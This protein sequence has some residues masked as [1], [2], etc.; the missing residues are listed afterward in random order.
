[1]SREDWLY[2]F[3][4]EILKDFAKY[5]DSKINARKFIGY[6]I[7]ELQRSLN[8]EKSV[9]KKHVIRKIIKMY[10]ELK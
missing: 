2:E 3:K 6:R 10:K 4:S 7:M 5:P 1:M 8:K 9:R